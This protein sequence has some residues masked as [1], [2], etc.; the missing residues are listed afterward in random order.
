MNQTLPTALEGTV[1][2]EVSGHV[3]GPYAGSLLG[4]IGCEVIKVELPERVTRTA[5]EI[6]STKVMD[7][8]SG[9]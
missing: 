2:I 3:A 9:P 8:A 5:A 7:Q 1:V 6:R 4:D